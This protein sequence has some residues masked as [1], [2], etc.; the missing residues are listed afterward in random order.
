MGLKD[1][2]HENEISASA[3]KPFNNDSPFETMCIYCEAVESQVLAGSECPS[4]K[5]VQ[6]EDKEVA[7]STSVHLKFIISGANERL[8]FENTK[9]YGFI[10]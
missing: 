6:A 1:S 2:V 7:V 10:L 5:S 9:M 4:Y 3:N 8:C